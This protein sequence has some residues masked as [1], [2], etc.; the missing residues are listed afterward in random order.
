M[1]NV[2]DSLLWQ[3]GGHDLNSLTSILNT[4]Y[5]DT[6]NDISLI[7]HSPYVSNDEFIDYC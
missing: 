6:N 2:T 4:V 5:D 1:A 3:Y 7:K